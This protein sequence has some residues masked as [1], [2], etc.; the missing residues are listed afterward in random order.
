MFGEISIFQDQVFSTYAIA[1]A[2]MILKAVAMSW[3]TVVQ[4]TRVN[5]GFRAPED[6]RKTRLNPSP[7]ANQTQP[8][9][10]VDRIRRIHL[11]DLE[12]I[13]FFLAAGFLWVLTKPSLLEAQ[14]VLY[15]YVITRLLH[16]AAYLSARS[17]DVRAM[18]WTP[19]SLIIIYMAVR[20]LM[21]A[22]AS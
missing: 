15:A 16:F 3:L 9:E 20:T 6:L 17:H 13:P 5:G 18:L 14:I 11:N 10:S 8:N 19:G 1:A 7:N 22:L 4:M 21:A 12:N 2:I